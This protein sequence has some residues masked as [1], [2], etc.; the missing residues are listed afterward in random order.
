MLILKMQ[1]QKAKKYLSWQLSCVEPD[2]CVYL[3][4]FSIVLI[5]N[6]VVFNGKFFLIG[7]RFLNQTNHNRDVIPSSVVAEYLV[8]NL[9]ITLEAWEL[10][11]IKW[12]GVKLTPNFPIL[13]DFFCCTAI[14]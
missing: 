3:K 10:D 13:S 1:F 2:N 4:E 7:R 5:K 11:Q 14:V 12:K 6:F 9:S 8:S